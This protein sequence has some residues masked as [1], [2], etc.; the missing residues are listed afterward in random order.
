MSA[1]ID[2][3]VLSRDS[4]DMTETVQ[5]DADK[6]APDAVDLEVEAVSETEQTQAAAP[7]AANETTTAESAILVAPEVVTATATVPEVLAEAATP[8]PSL[9]VD[10]LKAPLPADPDAL[11]REFTDS[12]AQ[13]A[14]LRTKSVEITE[15]ARKAAEEAARLAAEAESVGEVYRLTF[16]RYTSMIET[17]SSNPPADQREVSTRVA[18]AMAL[19]DEV[20]APVQSGV[21]SVACSKAILASIQRGLAE[22]LPAESPTL[23]RLSSL[24]T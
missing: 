1:S 5:P 9:T 11:L 24:G 6:V 21:D 7:A 14:T 2:G 12:R 22:P 20:N 8:M 15:Q 18:M 17:V 23:R 16:Q 19:L 10:A 4:F 13:V 3:F